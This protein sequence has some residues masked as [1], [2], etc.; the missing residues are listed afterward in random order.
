MQG[1]EWT[2]A[3]VAVRSSAPGLVGAG[4]ASRDPRPRLRGSALCRYWWCSVGSKTG[5]SYLRWGG[6]GE[7]AAD[8]EHPKSV[9]FPVS[10]PAGDAAVEFDESVESPMFVKLG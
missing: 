9:A 6:G 4:E 2:E 5:S 3:E 10:E 8:E 1:H 7:A